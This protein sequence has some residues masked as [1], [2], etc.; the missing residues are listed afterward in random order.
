MTLSSVRSPSHS[1]WRWTRTLSSP[2]ARSVSLFKGWEFE[3][4]SPRPAHRL[5]SIP[6]T[7]GTSPCIGLPA[8]PCRCRRR[9]SRAAASR[10][11]L[12]HLQGLPRK[13][14]ATPPSPVRPND[15]RPRHQGHARGSQRARGRKSWPHV[16]S[17]MGR[18]QRSA[19]HVLGA[20]APRA[21]LP[22]G[23]RCPEGADVG[24]FRRESHP[25]GVPN[26]FRPS[27]CAPRRAWQLTP[28]CAPDWRGVVA[29]C[30]RRQSRS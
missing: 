8:P 28:S 1:L 24:A 17:P 5:R 18:G 13:W 29:T 3:T 6:P 2:P 23:R 12:H 20:S 30:T 15:L 7:P 27:K 11:P 14:G 10:P 21:L 4:N 19:A 16:L 25:P 26:R 9:G 22:L